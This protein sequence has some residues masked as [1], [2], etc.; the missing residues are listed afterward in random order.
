MNFSIKVVAHT[1]KVEILLVFLPQNYRLMQHSINING[2]LLDLTTPKVMGIINATPDSFYQQSR[3]TDS[4]STEQR[5]RQLLDEGA[6]IIDIGAVSTRP[7]ASEVS[8]AEEMVRLRSCLATVTKA[9]PQA[10]LSVDTFRADVARMAVEEYGVAIINDISGGII[11]KQMFS[12]VA[13]LGIPYVLSD[14]GN[15]DE[16]TDIVDS[17]ILRF[18]RR[19]EELRSLGQK[20][21]LLD[22][23]FGFGKTLDQNYQ[24]L[25]RLDELKVF[26][27]PLL[28]GIS[29]KSMMH[30]LLNITPQQS[31]NATTAVHSYILSKHCADI[32]RVH[33]VREAV[34][35]I[36]IHQ[37]IKEFDN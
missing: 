12:T 8:E 27:L 15:H 30:R 35:T 33:D 2:Q 4:V 23:G 11:D 20:D 29:R 5:L 34:E 3:T 26:E 36:T 32:L 6:A 17:M 7:G 25:T 1:A 19:I 24:I 18:A 9:E 14:E 13:S 10:V 31:L 16:G 37:K 22:P 28:I 21:I